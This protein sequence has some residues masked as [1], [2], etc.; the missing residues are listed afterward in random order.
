MKWIQAI[1]I[2]SVLVI[3][4]CAS[5]KNPI[6]SEA[7][8]DAANMLQ[9][10]SGGNKLQLEF[11]NT[12]SEIVDMFWVDY[13]GKEQRK[14]SIPPNKVWKTVTYDFHPWVVRNSAGQCIKVF[15][16]NS[17]LKVNI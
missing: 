8:C 7:G 5:I 10:K 3:Q 4:G 13:Q 12:Q 2:I 1:S 9:S 11:V 17:V 15:N 14:G 6:V 16:I